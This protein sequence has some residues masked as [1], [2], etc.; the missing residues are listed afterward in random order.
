MPAP[1][2]GHLSW[3]DVTSCW[4]NRDACHPSLIKIN[5]KSP[6]FPQEGLLNIPSGAWRG[7][8]AASQSRGSMNWQQN[9]QEFFKIYIYI[10]IDTLFCL[11]A[12][13]GHPS[14]EF[15]S[16]GSPQSLL[17][18][19]HHY[20]LFFPRHPYTPTT[21]CP[22]RAGDLRNIIFRIMKSGV[23]LI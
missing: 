11:S 10:Y 2:T 4:L 21:R 9:Q 5:C 3:T 8:L 22:P 15:V 23:T 18:P 6:C 13:P 14:S 12:S 17:P 7:R 19:S 20:P 16:M 1:N